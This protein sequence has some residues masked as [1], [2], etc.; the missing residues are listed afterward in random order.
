[1][2]ITES[3]ISA[4]VALSLYMKTQIS[5]WILNYASIL[6]TGEIDPVEFLT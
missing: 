1:M 2:G 3:L 6:V 4:H 5:F